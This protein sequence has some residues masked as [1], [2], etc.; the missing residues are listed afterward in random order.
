MFNDVWQA[1]ILE[2]FLVRLA[3]S[4]NQDR[5]TVKGGFLL[6]KYLRLGRE[7]AD[8]DFLLTDSAG[9]V[10]TVRE[11]IDAI[12]SLPYDDGFTFEDLAV[13]E[14]HHPHMTHPG[15]EVNYVVCLGQ[16]RTMVRIDIG[17]G[18]LVSSERK[19]LILLSHN[20]RPLIEAEIS[21]PA[22]PLSF[23]FAEKLEA[24]VY[25]GGANGR[26][27][28]FYDIVLVSRMPNFD[29]IA[30]RAVVESVFAHRGTE[31]PTRLSYDPQA[32]STLS[33]S[34]TRFLGALEKESRKEMPEEFVNVIAHIDDLLKT[35][36]ATRPVDPI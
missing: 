13:E 34:W 24:V 21:I 7:T 30:E 36:R 32:M 26:M 35:L 1:M 15:Y 33:R 31:L 29:L 22:Y 2:R 10:E 8:L 4:E 16:T 11:L 17:I 18:D 20:D 9:S 12:L 3:R 28:D 27:K 5:L 23:I 6:S 14:R 19:S 25:R